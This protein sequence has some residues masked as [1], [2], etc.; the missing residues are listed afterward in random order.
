[1]NPQ[2]N[3]KKGYP[4]IPYMMNTNAGSFYEWVGAGV[5]SVK[6]KGFNNG[7]IDLSAHNWTYKIGPLT[8]YKAIVDPLP[9]R[10]LYMHGC[11]QECN[12][13]GKFDPDKCNTGCGEPTQR[14]YHVPRSWFKP[15]GN[16]PVIFEEKGGDYIPQFFFLNWEG[17]N[18]V[19]P[20][21]PKAARRGPKN[22][23]Y[24]VEG[25][26]VSGNTGDQNGVFNVGN[27]N[28]GCSRVADDDD[29]EDEAP[30][31]PNAARS[32]PRNIYYKVAGN[33]VGGNSGNNNG[34]FNVGNK[35]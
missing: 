29:E 9:G 1:M 14:W 32:G 24:K 25:N 35:N 10:A 15:S 7:T 8:W 11:V 28:S 20:I 4:K 18:N 33:R 21:K 31:K 17:I 13:R 12:Y 16:V 22:E 30:S 23:V 2:R 34:V 27:E 19:L 6:I 5:S 3:P 26:L